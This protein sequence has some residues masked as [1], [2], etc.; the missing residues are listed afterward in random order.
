MDTPSSRSFPELARSIRPW[1]FGAA[2]VIA[3]GFHFF[4]SHAVVGWPLAI[5]AILIAAGTI[6]ITQECEGLRN[7]WALWFLVPLLAAC[8]STTL[9]S[10]DVVKGVS[11][12][13]VAGS[14][15]ALAYW[16]TAPPVKWREGVHLW[17]TNV[18]LEAA[19]PF[20]R[21]QLLFTETNEG[22]RINSKLILQI[23][24]GLLI[25]GP[26]LLIFLSLFLEGDRYFNDV[27]SSWFT[28]DFMTVNVVRVFFDLLVA[29]FA[30][31][32]F[33]GIARRSR[34]EAVAREPKTPFQEIVATR[35]FLTAIATLF[36]VFAG[37]QV[38]YLFQGASY[39]LAQGHTYAEYAVSGYAQLCFAAAF[40]FLIL[41]VIYRLTNFEDRWVRITGQII[42]VTS[43]I[44]TI[45][46]GKRLWLYVDAYSLTLS[47]S[48]GMQFL[49]L[50]ILLFA[51]LIWSVT[52]RWNIHQLT[53]AGTALT[54]GLLSITLLVNHE[55]IVAR[56]NLSRHMAHQGPEL[57]M[58][59]LVTGLSADAVPTILSF[60]HDPNWREGHMNWISHEPIEDY[61][62]RGGD[63][64][65]FRYL[66]P[67][68]DPRQLSISDI[69]AK[70]LI[71][72]LPRPV[73]Y[74]S[75]K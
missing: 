60:I 22:R 51:L 26:V 48:W 42:A 27:M 53:T 41:L 29:F 66:K 65:Q 8:F 11:L 21:Y 70:Q 30:S 50:V 44:S 31:A 34:E 1:A 9:Y 18:F 5:F 19:L 36:V 46:A 71:E 43:I 55:A 33:W 4:F 25:A 3:L 17:K 59:Y 35:S 32:F 6:L 2:I 15:A 72:A 16:L 52:R 28:F 54:L 14:L 10:S 12:F 49:V 69:Q 64:G 74:P 56:Y 58:T 39:L 23:A 67:G 57:D 73:N 62:R 13:T 45:S 63:Y 20:R 75:A 24:I 37:F 38:F 7:R 61:W 68:T 40:A 47:R